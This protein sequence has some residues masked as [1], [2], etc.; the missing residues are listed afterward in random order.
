MFGFL[1]E[2]LICCSGFNTLKSQ[3]WVF[4]VS[5]IRT[6]SEHLKLHEII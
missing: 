5:V 2:L 3:C 1:N 4:F 6:Q